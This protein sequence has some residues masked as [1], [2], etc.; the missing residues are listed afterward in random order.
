MTKA[1]A[2]M[3]KEA[4]LEEFKAALLADDEFLSAIAASLPA[5]ENPGPSLSE[6]VYTADPELRSINIIGNC[7]GCGHPVAD[8]D[9]AC[10][11]CGESLED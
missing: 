6:A 4:L 1:K 8:G 9:T 3:E 10:I 7:S 2:K 5:R 11:S